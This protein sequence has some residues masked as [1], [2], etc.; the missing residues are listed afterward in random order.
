MTVQSPDTQTLLSLTAL[1]VADLERSAEF[2]IRGCGFVH[3][4]DLD[5]PTFHASIVR[6][7]AAGLELVLPT[8][9]DG[10]TPHDHGHM[11][12]KIVLNTDDVEGRMAD[13]CR[14]G[15]VEETPATKLEAYGMVIGTVRDPDGYL[16]EFVQRG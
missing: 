3:D 9:I 1:R 7:G 5:T 13:A 2:Y 14:H 4:K 11:F 8:G 12:V 6:A 10:E 16:V 15:G